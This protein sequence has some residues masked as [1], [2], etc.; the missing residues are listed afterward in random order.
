MDVEERN[1]SELDKLILTEYPYPIAVSYRR[2]MDTVD[3]PTR[4]EAALKVFEYSL[5][6]F[7][8][9]LIAQYLIHDYDLSDP[10]LNQFLLD[11]LRRATLGTWRMMFFDIL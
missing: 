9:S 1:Y 2:M 6:V 11:H 5:Q 7:T 10:I 8:F 3:W 4:V